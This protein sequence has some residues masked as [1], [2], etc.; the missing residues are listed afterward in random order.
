[1]DRVKSKVLNNRISALYRIQKDYFRGND[2]Q[3]KDFAT[4]QIVRNLAEDLVT[5]KKIVLEEREPFIAPPGGQIPGW[6]DE[7]T[8]YVAQ[9]YVFTPEEFHALLR[10][11]E[12]G[13]HNGEYHSVKLEAQVFEELMRDMK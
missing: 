9:L 7:V 1:M 12:A 13:F 3:M 5:H 6:A 10:E 4:R 11:I 8:E 2:D